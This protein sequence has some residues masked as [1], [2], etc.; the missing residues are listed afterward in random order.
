MAPLPVAERKKVKNLTTGK[1][2][3]LNHVAV[4]NRARNMSEYLE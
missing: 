4:V 3:G 1:I 2:V